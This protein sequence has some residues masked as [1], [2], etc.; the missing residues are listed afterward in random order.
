MII[1][2]LLA[3]FVGDY[4]LQWDALAQWKGREVKGA[5]V[6]SA[7]VFAVTW[8]LAVPFDPGFWPWVVFIGVTH[9]IVDATPVWVMQRLRRART[10]LFE[11]TRLL[12]DQTIH[13]SI[14]MLALIGGGYLRPETALAD[15]L[16]AAQATPWLT[17]V[18]TYVVVAMPAWIL[19]EFAVYGLLNGTPPDFA[20]IGPYK[21]VGT[22][23]RWLMT[24]FVLTGQLAL[25]PL[26]A[27]PRLWLET[28]ATPS[29]TTPRPLVYVAELLASVM[30]AVAAGLLARQL[31]QF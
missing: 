20:R 15:V 9:A 17:L 12:I 10:G 27:A 22:L 24:T 6:H 11:L 2:M 5:L 3:H 18:L 21:Y 23:E 16:A 7:I 28:R 8:L 19:V 1:A 30:L 29:A 26:V 13:L 25:V 14:I 31:L 4:V